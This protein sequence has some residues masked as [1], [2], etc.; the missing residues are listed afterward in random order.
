MAC[1]VGK[2]AAIINASELVNAG[3]GLS[4]RRGRRVHEISVKWMD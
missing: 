1:G 3:I 2:F 4:G